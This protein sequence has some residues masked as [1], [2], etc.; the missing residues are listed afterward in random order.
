MPLKARLA[1]LALFPGQAMTL[2][3]SGAVRRSRRC[4]THRPGGCAA[5]AAMTD[6]LA[7][8]TRV[9]KARRM[10]I[11]SVCGVP[12]IV[13]APIARLVSPAGWCHLTCVP[14][15]ARVLAAITGR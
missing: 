8:A 2:T 9:M 13:G 4:G 15:V 7:L 12:I 10:S 3:V 14:A 1:Q 6:R 11:C 5:G